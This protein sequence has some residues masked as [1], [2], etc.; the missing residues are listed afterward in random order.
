MVY[1]SNHMCEKI[2][3]SNLW[4]EIFSASQIPGCLWLA[5]FLEEIDGSL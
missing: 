5:I 1:C 3:V 2:L 4:S